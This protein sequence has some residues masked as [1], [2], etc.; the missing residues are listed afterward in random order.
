MKTA[1]IV[2]PGR[3][4]YDRAALGQLQGRATELLDA[5]D[6]WRTANGR[7][8]VRE[9][10]AA[11]AYRSSLHVAGEHASLLTF[12]C[13]M[14]D[15]GDLS[16]TYDVVGVV[17]NSMGFY[18]ALAASGALPLEDAIRLV[19][20]MG[21]YQTRNVIGGQVLYPMCGSDWRTTPELRAVVE[22]ALAAVAA[23]GHVAEWS[24]ELGGYAVLGADRDGTKALLELL[25]PVERGS[26]TF[27]VQLPLHS[28]F[29]TSLMR[30]T[31]ARAF[32]ELGELGFRAPSVP[33]I[34]GRGMVFRP[35]WA[36]PSALRDYTLGHQV[37]A[38]FDFTRAVKTALEHTGADVVVALGPGNGLGGPLARTIVECHWRGIVDRAGFEAAQA[39]TDPVLLAFGI[40][41]QRALLT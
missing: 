2:A 22:D 5:C 8:T 19:D 37:T 30:D 3:G 40:P 38:P 6:A 36:D 1:L 16:D 9:L 18:T 7:P 25:P 17:G 28:A 41:E 31:S 35:R 14:A 13:S 33:L 15:L 11:D 29:H 12:A 24:I 34:D 4:S 39:S 23:R 27:P 21:A 20:T 32:G 26:R 10:D